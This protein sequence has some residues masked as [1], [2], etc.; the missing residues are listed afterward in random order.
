MDMPEALVAGREDIYLGWFY[1]NYGHRP[2]A[3]PDAD[4]AEYL[5]CY[6]QPGALRAGFSFYR[7]ILRDVADN[8]AIVARFKLPMPVLALG[9]GNAWG[10]RMAVVESLQRMAVNVRGGVIDQCG[11]WMPEEQPE[12]LLGHLLP[13]LSEHDP[14]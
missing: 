6:R 10:R 1:R 11:H 2:D 7:N 12:A 4:I 13:F 3:I 8:E 9:G 14:A 5:R